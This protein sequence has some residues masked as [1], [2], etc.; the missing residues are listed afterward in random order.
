MNKKIE[1]LQGLRALAF[2]GVFASHTYLKSFRF[3]GAWGVSVFFMLSGFL[4]VHNYYNKQKIE[5]VTLKDNFLFAAHKIALIYPLHILMLFFRSIFYFTGN[6][7][8]PIFDTIKTI[9]FDSLLIN[10][11]F[12]TIGSINAPAWYLCTA[13]LAYFLF[14]YVLKFMERKYSIKIAQVTIIILFVLQIM[15]GIIS[16]NIRMIDTTTG[17]W[18]CYALPPARFIDVFIGCNLGYLFQNT[19]SNGT[20]KNHTL[21][22]ITAVC[23]ALFAI[24]FNTIIDGNE[25]CT[26]VYSFTISSCMLV[27]LF[28]KGTGAISSIISNKVFLWIASLSA[29][30]FLIHDVVFWYIEVTLYHSNILDKIG[31]TWLGI[32]KL[33]LGFAITM[34]ISKGYKFIVAKKSNT[35]N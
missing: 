9:V 20:E 2:L 7:T 35:F 26:R 24:V 14:P 13:V 25:H 31:Y 17:D 15:I 27:W 19:P 6:E 5:N 32:I 18:L 28:A 22:E 10:A 8:Q 12:P 29:Y 11:W 1:S 21:Y 34:I 23:F 33:I 16:K 3:T 4:L 30:A